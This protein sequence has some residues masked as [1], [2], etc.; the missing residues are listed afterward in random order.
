MRL[1]VSR[2]QEFPVCHDVCSASR[3]AISLVPRVLDLG[4]GGF[5]ANPGHGCR[6]M[7]ALASTTVAV[8]D[9]LARECHGKMYGATEAASMRCER[10]HERI[11]A[12]PC[13]DVNRGSKYAKVIL[14]RPG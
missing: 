7:R 2:G 14:K 3:L 13:I 6:A 4:A 10:I 8:C 9:P 5:N 1:T 11:H 12:R